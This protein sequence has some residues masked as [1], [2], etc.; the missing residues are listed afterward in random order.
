LQKKAP[1]L[2]TTSNRGVGFFHVSE[3]RFFEFWNFNGKWEKFTVDSKQ[4]NALDQFASICEKCF[5]VSKDGFTKVSPKMKKAWDWDLGLFMKIDL[6]KMM[7]NEVRGFNQLPENV[8]YPEDTRESQKKI[9]FRVKDR[10]FFFFLFDQAK[11]AW[12]SFSLN[13]LSPTARKDFCKL[14]KESFSLSEELICF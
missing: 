10:R 3:G 12:K 13:V 8:L 9:H 7:R 2:D 11:K 5:G 14:W 4:E 1:P 6:R